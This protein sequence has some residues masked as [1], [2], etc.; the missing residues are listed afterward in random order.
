MTAPVPHQGFQLKRFPNASFWGPLDQQHIWWESPA[1][2]RARHG[3]DICMVSQGQG[4][5]NHRG[6][7]TDPLWKVSCPGQEGGKAGGRSSD[8]RQINQQKK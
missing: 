6:M 3:Q 8:E 4:V 7:K 5:G 1:V 2:V